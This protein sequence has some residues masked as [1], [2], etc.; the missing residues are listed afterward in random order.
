MPGLGRTDDPTFVT[1]M[2]AINRAVVNPLFL[3][4]IF[5][6][7]VFLVWAGLLALDSARGWLLAAG[8]VVFFLG[9][10]V[11]TVAGNVPLN[12]ALDGST[13]SATT[14]RAAFER[15]W[16]ALNGVRSVASVVAI[17]GRGV[18]SARLAARPLRTAGTDGAHRGVA[19]DTSLPDHGLTLALP[20][21]QTLTLTPPAR[22][23]CRTA[24]R[25]PRGRASRPA[26]PRTCPARR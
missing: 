1:S 3:L 18:G 2:R 8:G 26:R 16:N 23:R 11:V 15:R 20:R 9:A 24:A 10:V 5:L 12:N 7:P 25:S 4:P 13:T 17:A 19:L 22:T 21:T 6:P 14:T